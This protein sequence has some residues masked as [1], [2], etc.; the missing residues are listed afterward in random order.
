MTELNWNAFISYH[1]EKTDEAKFLKG[2]EFNFGMKSEI[3][4]DKITREAIWM[5]R[6]NFQVKG[7]RWAYIFSIISV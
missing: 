7:V 4:L 1:I 6:S 5:H 2:K 3:L